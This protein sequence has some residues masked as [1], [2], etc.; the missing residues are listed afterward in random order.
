MYTP[1]H[2]ESQEPW[3]EVLR[4][5][6]FG[7][8]VSTREGELSTTHLPYRVSSDG[9]QI[10]VHMARANPHWRLL[11]KHPSCCLL[12]QGDH[13]YVSP[14]WYASKKSVPTWNYEAVHVDATAEL[15]RDS[16]ELW[17]M[18]TRMSDHFEEESSPWSHS[19]L[20]ESVRQPLLGA[21]I[22]VRLQIDRAHAKQKLS[23][24]RPDADRRRVAEEL[25]KRGEGNLAD[26]MLALLDG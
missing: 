15:V 17:A 11:E 24:N 4:R 9:K 1:D 2:F 7:I 5:H 10:E 13:A 23:Q 21:I 14:S 12:V 22:G 20:P 19:A 3:L 26:Q 6:A 8:L 16:D 18:V 25:R